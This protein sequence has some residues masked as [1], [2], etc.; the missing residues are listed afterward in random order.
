MFIYESQFV[1]TE[2][3]AIEGNSQLVGYL[4]QF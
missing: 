2:K 3:L 1:E 4:G